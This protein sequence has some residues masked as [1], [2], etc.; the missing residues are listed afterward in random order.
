VTEIL[1]RSGNDK[2]SGGVLA[3]MFW[4]TPKSMRNVQRPFGLEGEGENR[5]R[6]TKT[7]AAAGSSANHE[8]WP[9]ILWTLAEDFVGEVEVSR[10]Q[11]V[12]QGPRISRQW[13]VGP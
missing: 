7:R 3:V 10:G 5:W 6:A 12:C 9:I 11:L 2:K 4:G 8:F 1:N 13:K